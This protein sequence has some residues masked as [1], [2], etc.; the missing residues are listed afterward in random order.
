MEQHQ[1]EKENVETEMVSEPCC[2]FSSPDVWRKTSFVDVYAVNFG[3]WEVFLPACR[4]A[5]CGGF[6][7]G[8]LV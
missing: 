6:F 8:C 3:G 2:R 7:K 4:T 1:Q 5:A